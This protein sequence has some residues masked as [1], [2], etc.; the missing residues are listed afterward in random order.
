MMRQGAPMIARA[1]SVDAEPEPFFPYSVYMAASSHWSAAG[2][3]RSRTAR[4]VVGGLWFL[5]RPAADHTH[6]DAFDHQRIAPGVD[7]DR[8][9]VGIFGEQRDFTP[10]SLQ[11]FDRYFVAARRRNARDDDLPAAGFA[12]PVHREQI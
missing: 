1:A 7:D 5:Q 6:T 2:G 12:A 4:L 9:E 11:P 3:I 8:R 10:A